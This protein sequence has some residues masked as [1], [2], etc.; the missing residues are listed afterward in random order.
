[1]KACRR[2]SPFGAVRSSSNGMGILLRDCF[3]TPGRERRNGNGADWPLWGSHL[4]GLT[5]QQKE[6]GMSQTDVDER[7]SE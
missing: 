4:K 3:E 5:K 2:G 7:W 1:M 6:R